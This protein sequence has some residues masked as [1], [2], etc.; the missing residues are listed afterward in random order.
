MPP[1]A[2]VLFAVEGM[3]AMGC[4]M[5]D[6]A[7]ERL[8]A[9]VPVPEAGEEGLEVA[10]ERLARDVA[11]RVE[12]AT[13]LQEAD[14]HW[15]WAT[16]EEAPQAALQEPGRVRVTPTLVVERGEPREEPAEAESLVVRLVPG[17]GFGD[18]QHPTTRATLAYLEAVVRPGDHVLDLGA[19]SGVLAVTAALLGA[20]K[21]DAV[22]RDPFACEAAGR[23]AQVNGVSDRV[24]VVCE[25]VGPGGLEGRGPWHGV[26]ANVV[27]GI[28]VPL[29]PDLA[30]ELAPGGWLILAGTSVGE[31]EGV[32][33]AAT[34]AGLQL[35]FQ[36]EDDG[37]WSAVLRKAR[38]A[39]PP[40]G[41]SPSA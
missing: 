19:G 13:S 28:L 30:A 26:L 34:G 25:A 33:E 41:S 32:A 4:R 24:R 27:P 17:L 9:Y 20:E 11:L 18:A 7:G 31:K 16:G 38:R 14:P 36:R 8:V 37:W 23:N 6:R 12:A 29:L 2:E 3:A 39:R 5:T 15:W 40:K 35:E 21:V 1:R 10:A 22:E